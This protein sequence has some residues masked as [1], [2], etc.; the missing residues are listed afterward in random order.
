MTRLRTANML[1]AF[2]GD[3]S[4]RA[5]AML[6]SHP[7]QTDS[8]FA[9]LNIMSFWEG[10]TNAQLAKALKLS[11]TATVRLVDKLEARGFVQARRGEDKRATHLFLTDTGRGAAEP[12]LVARCA[13]MTPYLDVLS[14]D[15]EKQLSTLLEKLMRPLAK[16]AYGVSHFCRLCDFSACPEDQCPMHADMDKWAAP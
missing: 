1:A 8:A 13:A 12:M 14:V 16:D 6:K 7:N 5:N 10:I 4:E 2:A 9:A 3:V 15:E 11:H